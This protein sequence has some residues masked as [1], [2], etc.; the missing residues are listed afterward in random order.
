M[1]GGGIPPGRVATGDE[2]DRPSGKPC[3]WLLRRG[4]ENAWAGK[5]AP[6]FRGLSLVK[7]IS[8]ESTRKTRN[9]IW[10]RVHSQESAANVISLSSALRR[11]YRARSHRRCHHG[12]GRNELRQ[13]YQRGA[14]TAPDGKGRMKE[15]PRSAV[16]ALP[17]RHSA[18]RFNWTVSA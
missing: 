5:I 6:D 17:P 13:K 14:G 10:F 3:Q 9:P 18:H 8:R 4:I 16:P 11:C 1:H 7:R 2:N 12:Y 15:A